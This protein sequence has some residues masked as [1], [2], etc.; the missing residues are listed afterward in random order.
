MNKGQS[1]IDNRDEERRAG[2]VIVERR[3]RAHYYAIVLGVPLPRIIFCAATRGRSAHNNAALGHFAPGIRREIDFR[4]SASLIF[5]KRRVSY[6]TV[7][8]TRRAV[9]KIG[10]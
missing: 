8:Y 5:S 6:K 10:C 4:M 1:R 9:P 2:E 3:R 7:A